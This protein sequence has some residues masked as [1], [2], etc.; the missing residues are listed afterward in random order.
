M[1]ILL[2]E[3]WLLTKLQASSLSISLAYLSVVLLHEDKHYSFKPFAVSTVLKKIKHQTR[4]N[5]LCPWKPWIT[6]VVILQ[7]LHT[8]AHLYIIINFIGKYAVTCNIFVINFFLKVNTSL[9][10]SR[11]NQVRVSTLY[12]A[13]YILQV[14]F[15]LDVNVSCQKFSQCWIFCF[16]SCKT[17]L[18]M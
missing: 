12:T 18:W 16:L 14:E 15:S 1:C 3:K 17:Q 2:H 4:L 9:I 8:Y 5:V 6:F 13:K 11:L 7:A 10:I